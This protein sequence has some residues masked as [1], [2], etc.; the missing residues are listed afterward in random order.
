MPATKS[1]DIRGEINA[2]LAFDPCAV[3][4]GANRLQPDCCDLLSEIKRSESA[5]HNI[6]ADES[7]ERLRD[8]EGQAI[9]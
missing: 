3:I 7:R 9:R 5:T 8:A 1:A 4:L 6:L 2:V